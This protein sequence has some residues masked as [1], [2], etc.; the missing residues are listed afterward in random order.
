MIPLKLSKDDEIVW[1]D[2]GSVV[3]VRNV[4][5]FKARCQVIFTPASGLDELE[6]I[7]TAEAVALWVDNYSSYRP[8]ENGRAPWEPAPV[9]VES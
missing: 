3:K 9:P 4:E 8:D 6:V 7:G 5:S 2:E 1:V